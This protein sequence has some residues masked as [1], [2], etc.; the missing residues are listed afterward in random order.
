MKSPC[1]NF[2]V[3][4]TL[5][6]LLLLGCTESVTTATKLLQQLQQQSLMGEVKRNFNPAQIKRGHEIFLKNCAVCHGQNGEGTTDWRK[7]LANGRYPAPP[8]D[9][10][11]HAWHHSTEELKR[12]ILKGGPPGEGRMPEWQD[13]LSDQEI[14]DIL[15]WIKSLWSDD[16]YEAWYRQIENR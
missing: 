9:S 7:P 6:T 15:V 2:G 12:F 13:K 5:C 4:V 11:A 14:D 1:S 3:S 10:A 8:L 16:I